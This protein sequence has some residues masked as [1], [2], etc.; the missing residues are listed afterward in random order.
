MCRTRSGIHKYWALM[1]GE[2][3]KNFN[4]FETISSA[5]NVINL[6]IDKVLFFADVNCKLKVKLAH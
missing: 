6:N 5:S 3:I 1:A 2:N 4:K